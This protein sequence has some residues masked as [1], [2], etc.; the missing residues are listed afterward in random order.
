MNKILSNYLD[1]FCIAYLDDILIYS[2]DLKQHHWHIKM[3]L[4]SIEE[5]R[6][7]LKVSKYEFHTNKTEYLRYI[8]SPIGI[9]IDT[10]KVRVVAEWKEPI[11]MKGVQSFLGF[12]NL[13][14]RFIRDCSKIIALLI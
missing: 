12:A 10:D 1:I 14:R 13:Y 5:V 7:I 8:I 4:R 3:I 2:D 11:N 6:L 9:K